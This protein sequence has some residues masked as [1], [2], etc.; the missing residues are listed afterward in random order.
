M[1]ISRLVEKVIAVNEKYSEELGVLLVKKCYE[2]L[3]NLK[4]SIDLE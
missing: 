4:V 2:I 3:R 1:Y